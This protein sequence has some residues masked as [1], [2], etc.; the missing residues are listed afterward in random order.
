MNY[1]FDT[2]FIEAKGSIDLISIGIVAEDGREYYAVNSDMPIERVEQHLWLMLNVV[3]TLPVHTST[4]NAIERRRKHGENV[5]PRPSMSLDLDMS[6]T[7]VKPHWVIANEVRDFLLV[8]GKPELWANY[9]A[10]DHVVLM[11]LWGTMV[12]K[13]KGLPMFT[14]DL[15]HEISRLE[16]PE[17][18]LPKQE[19]SVHNALSDAWHAV[20]LYRFLMEWG[21]KRGA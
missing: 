4:L 19:G 17:A 10:Y 12:Q 5:H 16:V 2:E 8:D 11:W 13:P 20:E 21:N 15:Q 1:W 6:S 18:S 14:H 3:P 7:Q 9:C